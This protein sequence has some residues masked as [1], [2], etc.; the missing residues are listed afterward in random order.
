MRL[1]ATTVGELLS[2]VDGA[3]E[4]ERAVIVNV[5]VQRLEVCGSIDDTDVTSLHEVI[6]DDDVLLVG[7]DLDVVRT[8]GGLILI[9]VVKALDVVQVGDI[10]GSDVVGGGESD[11][12]CLSVS[13]IVGAG[14]I[15]LTVCELAVRS[16]VRV[17]G[18]G[19]TSFGTQVV[20]ELG[21][22][23]FAIGILPERIDD[24]DLAQ[25]NSSGNSSRLLVS[26]DELDVLNATTIGNSNGVGD[27]TIR[28]PPETK[29]VG[30][31]DTKG[32]L[33]NGDGNDKVR[34]KD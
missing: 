27:S 18:H 28:K 29:S 6:R 22:A 2:E 11:C 20:E 1:R 10:E 31:L 33:E 17:D 8:N 24:P 34:G 15:K 3:V 14:D 4:A 16:D 19:V 26:W 9:G 13:Q 12:K 25:V 21:F 5:N 23:E 30:S 7:G 32:R